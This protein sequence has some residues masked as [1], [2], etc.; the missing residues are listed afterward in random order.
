[1]VKILGSKQ[2]V[3]MDDANAEN[4]SVFVDDAD[5]KLKFKDTNGNVDGVAQDSILGEL[6]SLAAQN[7]IRQLE[8]RT[9][10]L[11]GGYLD[12]FAEA[13]TDENG[14]SNTVDTSDADNTACYIYDDIVGVVGT[15]FTYINPG[16]THG[17]DDLASSG[18]TAN[19]G[20]TNPENAFDGDV[21][22]NASASPGYG[23][24]LNVSLGKTFTS[25]YVGYAYVKAQLRL[26]ASGN[27]PNASPTFE[28]ETYNGS[29][30]TTIDSIV[31]SGTITENYSR[32]LIMGRIITV[33]DT[34]QGIRVSLANAAQGQTQPY[35]YIYD[36]RYGDLSADG[37]V[38]Q[39]IPSGT[40]SPTVDKCIGVP[41]VVNWETGGDIQYKITNSTE[42]S[43]WLSCGITPGTESFTAFT[44]EP[45][46]LIIKL[47][48]KTSP[49]PEY[50]SI[51]GFFAKAT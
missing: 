36:I 1:M 13:Y 5:N 3:P 26:R 30:W 23:V 10:S 31:W 7:M 38:V 33:D 6:Y 42:D 15:S 19:S 28:V 51:G 25:T 4:N 47:I 16:F 40:F 45:D 44:S 17:I 29:I 27:S 22:T 2:F 48:P 20:T 24:A 39:T 11:S 32:Y 43:G 35:A 8:D 50:P 18:S 46:T 12:G 9:L 21:N 49:T 41:K 34:I 37:Q 14:R